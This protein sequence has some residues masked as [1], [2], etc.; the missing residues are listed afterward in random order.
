[1][2]K[3]VRIIFG[4]QVNPIIM[5]L[6]KQ[7]QMNPHHYLGFMIKYLEEDAIGNDFATH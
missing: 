4:H 6:H 3:W 2:P 7:F 1:M 5:L